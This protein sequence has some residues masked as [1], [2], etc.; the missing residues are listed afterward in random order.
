MSC[1]IHL[2]LGSESE[3]SD[4]TRSGLTVTDDDELSL[5]IGASWFHDGCSTNHFPGAV[6]APEWAL[7]TWPFLLMSC[8]HRLRRRRRRFQSSGHMDRQRAGYSMDGWNLRYVLQV[9]LMCVPLLPLYMVQNSKFMTGL[10]S[11]RV[12][13]HSFP[14]YRLGFSKIVL[15]RQPNPTWNVHV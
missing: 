3:S 13:C 14:V 9:S 1:H 6:E 4:K 10:G 15:R 7:I 12:G 5:R 11:R 2:N 8:S